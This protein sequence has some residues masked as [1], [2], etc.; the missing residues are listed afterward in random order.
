MSLFPVNIALRAAS[1]STPLSQV[2]ESHQQQVVQQS[3]LWSTKPST[4]EVQD[5]I[6]RQ[7]YKR[8]RG[9]LRYYCGKTAR[10]EQP[11]CTHRNA[12]VWCSS[13]WQYAHCLDGAELHGKG[14]I[15]GAFR[16]YKVSFPCSSRM[17]SMERI[18]NFI[19]MHDKMTFH[20]NGRSFP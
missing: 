13:L 6:P 4:K 7:C 5:E 15:L 11:V 9:Y 1:T 17:Y 2:K 8:T 19:I 10:V 20:K 18:S 3:S 16:S 14:Y 12:V